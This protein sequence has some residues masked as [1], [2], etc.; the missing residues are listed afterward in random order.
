M[1]DV[2]IEDVRAYHGKLT[3]KDKKE[4][5]RD[6]RNKEFQILLATE[7]YEVG[8]DSPHV[9]NVFRVGCMQNAGVIVQEFGRAR[10]GGEQSD[11]Y[12]LINEHKDDQR[13]NYWTKQCKPDEEVCVKKKYQELWKWIYGIYN[14]TCLRTSLLKWFEDASLLEQCKEGECCSSCDIRQTSDFKGQE[15]AT[16]LLHGI[17][18]LEALFNVSDGINEDKLISWLLGAKRDWIS[19][20]EIQADID[21]STTFAK[22]S[23]HNGRI[24]NHAW[25]QRHLLQLISLGLVEIVFVHSKFQ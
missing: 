19:K 7:S 17:N 18:E 23:K 22:G 2:G 5:D 14:G 6:F 21:K 24:L 8:T 10:R 25:W 11:G 12:L 13:L 9:H 3:Q 20:P 4:I 16:L 1:K 15:T